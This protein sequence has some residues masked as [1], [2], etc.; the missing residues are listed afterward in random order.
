[1]VVFARQA[2]DLAQFFARAMLTS[3]LQKRNSA[4]ERRTNLLEQA[5]SFRRDGVQASHLR[6]GMNWPSAGRK[7]AESDC[8]VNSCAAR[9]ASS[10]ASPCA[11]CAA[12]AEAS[13]HPDPW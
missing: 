8:Q 10:M 13:V 11:S 4:I 2:H 12:H 6:R 3:V 1:H 5:R 7:P 9:T